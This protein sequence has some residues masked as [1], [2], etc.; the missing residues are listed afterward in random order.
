MIVRKAA[1]W[2]V[3]V[4]LLALAAF[5]LSRYAHWRLDRQLDDSATTALA[6]RLHGQSP[7]QWNLRRA[8]EVIAGRAF[9][10]VTSRFDER[11]MHIAATAAGS[12]QVGLPI[13][14]PI[15]LAHFSE[16]DVDADLPFPASV[17]VL[18][19]ERLDAG[20]CR[21][22]PIRVATSE[23]HIDLRQL[24]WR[25]EGKPHAMPTRAAMLRLQF[26]LSDGQRITLRGIALRQ[27]SGIGARRADGPVAMH[28]LPTRPPLSDAL[29]R[30][31]AETSHDAQP[32]VELPEGGRVEQ[33]L[34]TRDAVREAIPGAIA[35]RSGQGAHVL[36]QA[37][38]RPWPPVTHART[39]GW[40]AVAIW[41]ILLI[42]LRLYP[43]RQ[44]RLR[45]AAEIVAALGGPLWYALAGNSDRANG[46]LVVTSLVFAASLARHGDRPWRLRGTPAS[47]GL[48]ALSV[49]LGVASVALLHRG[50]LVLTH[51]DELAE[52][53]VRYTAWA[54]IQQYLIC[55]IVLDRA[56]QLLGSGRWAVLC[57]AI[58]F[59]LMHAP[60]AM[61][62]QLT[63]FAGLLWAA[64]WQRYRALLPNIVAHALCGLIFANTLPVDW[65]RSA[66]TGMRFFG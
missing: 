38:E 63:L 22:S 1:G 58:A 31:V 8:G 16:L 57:V 46:L 53:I 30:L 36:V 11:G 25:C 60:N 23:V 21:S 61:L 17:V 7:Y 26:E 27:L 51:H 66:E 39:A 56:S 62:M 52:Y 18:V 64:N 14:S 2:L 3:F 13:L 12:V 49:A 33:T 34:A 55:V 35:V 32:M 65:L 10:T 24:H 44:P 50:P 15:G 54:A 37:R 47:W 41:L 40:I 9:G 29:N 43:P 5:A 19:R 4:A 42:A 20:E 28:R 48:P 59:A 6:A 45:A